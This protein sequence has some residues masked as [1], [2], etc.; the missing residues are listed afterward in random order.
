MRK[1][2]AHVYADK[3]RYPIPRELEQLPPAEQPVD[4]TGQ[5][6]ERKVDLEEAD[7]FAKRLW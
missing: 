6:E 2:V 7:K 5:L 3:V 1:P 4:E